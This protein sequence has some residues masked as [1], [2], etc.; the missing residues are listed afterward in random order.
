[1]VVNN[2]ST[3]GTRAVLAEYAE[4][5]RV[6]VLYNDRDRG[7]AYSFNRAAAAAE[8]EL[9][10]VLGDDDRW[11][12][13]EVAK[14]VALIDSLPAAYGVVYTGGVM[15]ADGLVTKRYRPRRRGDIYPEILVEFGLHPHS[16]HM[17]RRA[18]FEAVGGFDTDFPRGVDWDL[19]IRLAREYGFECVDEPLVRRVY[20]GSNVSDDLAQVTVRD[21]IAGKYA[22]ELARHPDVGRRFEAEHERRSA[23]AEL[24]W[25]D[26]SAALAHGLRGFR[27]APS[28]GAAAD[29]AL[30]LSGPRGF[31]AAARIR[32]RFVDAFG[33][34]G[35][36][37]GGDT[38]VDPEIARQPVTSD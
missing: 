13:E 31:R 11:H 28:L 38:R 3:D 35:T 29:V 10:C 7:I 18:A 23:R 9:L 16:G 37:T 36:D 26:R 12:P 4:N 34:F 17:I 22:D 19:A 33:P 21:R 2:G 30:A 32:R 5:D 25:G 14:Q 20:H 15:V 27:A 8:G 1:V 6:R 24:K